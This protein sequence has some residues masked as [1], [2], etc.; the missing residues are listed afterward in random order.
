MKGGFTLPSR[1]SR[2]LTLRTLPCEDVPMTAEPIVTTIREDADEPPLLL[3]RLRTIRR[4]IDVEARA[5]LSAWRPNI[6][7]DAF[8][9]SA[10]NLAHYLALR[11][12][13]LRDMQLALMPLG[14]SSLG[15]CESR[16]LQNLD[17]V[18][19]ALARATGEPNPQPYPTPDAFFAGQ[20]A[21]R[22]IARGDLAVNIGYRR[23]AEIQEE[24]LWLC[25]SAHVPVI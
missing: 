6:R 14:L 9:P 2:I 18:I 3:R 21:L 23:L 20:T 24:I 15:R 10:L 8:L 16:V 11:R 7:R 12:R 17:A 19:A 5:Q 1:G 22:T 25:E 4:E 13:D